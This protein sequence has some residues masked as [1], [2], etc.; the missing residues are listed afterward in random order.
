MLAYLKNEKSF[1]F[2]YDL[3]VNFFDAYE[4]HSKLPEHQ[5][6]A[7]IRYLRDLGYVKEDDRGIGFE[8][9]HK[10][11]AKTELEWIKNWEFIRKS[12]IVPIIVA[13]LTTILTLALL[14]T[15]KELLPSWLVHLLQ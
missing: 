2:G 6:M 12:V 9:E 13:I 1:P 8:L 11:Y 5:I 14:N 7:C 4:E 15:A 3:F 10:A